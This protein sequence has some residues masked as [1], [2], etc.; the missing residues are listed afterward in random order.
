MRPRRSPPLLLVVSLALAPLAGCKSCSEKTGQPSPDAAASVGGLTPEQAQKTLAKFGDHVITLGDFARVLAEMPEY[1]R[2][3]YQSLERRKEL[4]RSMIDV[5]LLADEAKRQ[6]LDKDPAV[7][8]E[9]RQILVGWMR[10]KLLAEVPQASTIP[11]ADVK[12][13]YAAHQDLFR[14]PERRRLAQ[15]VTRDEAT[16]KK[17]AE[18]AKSAGASGWGALVKKYSDDKPGPNEAPELSGDLG[19]ATAATDGPGTTSAKLVPEV[20]AAGFGLKEVGAVSD[21]VKDAAGTFHVVRL[22]A[23]Q[24]ARAQT[25]QDVDRTIRVRI[26]Q[27]KRAEREKQLLDET[28]KSVKVEIDEAALSQVAASLAAGVPFAPASSGS[29]S[30]SASASASASAPASASAGKR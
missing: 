17:A 4:L 23:K 11:E 6:G 14:E 12:A 10:G 9:T 27:E 3:R 1:E 26:V 19:Y 22:L 21:A 13:Y 15:I 18:E 30:V 8:E 25:L 16:A 29:A 28:R 7:Q 5:Q 20:R 2:L 24:D